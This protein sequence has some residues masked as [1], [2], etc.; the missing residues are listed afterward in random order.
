M[1]K[2]LILL[3]TNIFI[4]TLCAQQKFE[5]TSPDGFLRST[6]KSGEQLTYIILCT[7]RI[8]F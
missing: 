8:R 4:F 5:L 6:I 1:K 2:I 3:L 7:E